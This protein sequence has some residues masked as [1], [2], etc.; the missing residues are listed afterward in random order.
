MK[1][2]PERWGR[3][4]L[5]FL[6]GYLCCVSAFEWGQCWEFSPF[7]FRPE[8]AVL[9]SAA[10]LGCLSEQQ[11]GRDR[12]TASA[13]PAFLW[14]ALAAWPLRLSLSTSVWV[15]SL[16]SVALAL[17]TLPRAKAALALAVALPLTV[18]LWHSVPVWPVAGALL[19]LT[20]LGM[21][22]QSR[23]PR[24]ASRQEAHQRLTADA[25][26][27]TAII[28]WQGFADLFH[29]AAPGEGERFASGLLNDTHRII[30]GC[31]GRKVKDER[32]DDLYRFPNEGSL[33]RCVGQLERYRTQVGEVLVEAQA[34]PVQLVVSRRNA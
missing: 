22:R 26:A 6:S 28:S 15:F 31:G 1:L 8:V 24:P 30:E 3:G 19:A 13:V 4:A 9:C 16:L 25:Q 29:A 12:R 23:R 20:M 33:D 32:A 11:T 10:F 14:T 2:R 17:A 34:P 18:A 5:A 7:V 27:R 21:V